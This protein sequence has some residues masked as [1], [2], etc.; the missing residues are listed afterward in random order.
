VLATGVV[1][2]ASALESLRVEVERLARKTGHS[3]Q[4]RAA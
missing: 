4:V 2:R 1:V 3:I